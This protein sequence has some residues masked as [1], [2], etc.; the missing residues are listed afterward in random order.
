MPSRRRQTGSAP[1]QNRLALHRFVCREFGYEDMGEM[2]RS[3]ARAPGELGAAGGESEYFRA[4]YLPPA[5]RVTLD[6]FAEYDADIGALSR[7]LRMTGEH[8]RTWK[9]HQ[10]LALLLPNTTS[11]ATSTTPRRSA[12]T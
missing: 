5:A 12:P 9:P 3:L 2:L 6:R 1:L 4:L 8:G 10:Y 7:R 11:A